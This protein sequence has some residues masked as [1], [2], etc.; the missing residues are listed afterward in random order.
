MIISVLSVDRQVIL[1]ATALM[2]SVMVVMNLTILPRTAPTAFHHQEHHANTEDL[3]QDINTTTTV[4]T[5]QTSIMVPDL[6]DITAD[7]SPTPINTMTEATTLEGTPYSLLPSITA[8]HA[9]LQ[10][11]DAPT[12]ITTGIV[13]SHPALVISP[14]GTTHTTPWTKI[15]HSLQQPPIHHK[16]LGLGR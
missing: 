14:A 6:G 13:T 5:D 15:T 4:E 12:M 7:H 9:T 3:I 8:A 11:K 2:C 1:A 10:P 16:I